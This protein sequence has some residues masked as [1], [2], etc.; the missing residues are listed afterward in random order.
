MD[1]QKQDL[2]LVEE[3]IKKFVNAKAKTSL[4]SLSRTREINF[5]CPKSYRIDKKNKDKA[6]WEYQDGDKLKSHNPSLANTI[7]PQ[8]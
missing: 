2:D 8:T 3:V 4:Q 5:R 6:N 1:N 7:E